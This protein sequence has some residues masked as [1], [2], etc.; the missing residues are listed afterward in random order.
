MR[1]KLSGLLESVGNSVCL[2]DKKIRYNESRIK[3]AQKEIRQENPPFD[4]ST[5]LNFS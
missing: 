3:M 1:S 4:R 2:S 5:T